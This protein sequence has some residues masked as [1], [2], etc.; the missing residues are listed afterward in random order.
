MLV[1]S[2]GYRLPAGAVNLSFCFSVSP[3]CTSRKAPGGA[4]RLP[5]EH[6]G[7]PVAP[8]C[9]AYVNA[10]EH[11][12]FLA[13][14]AISGKEMAVAQAFLGRR[15]LANF[16]EHCSGMFGTGGRTNTNPFLKKG[17]G[18]FASV[19]LLCVMP[20]IPAHPTLRRVEVLLRLVARM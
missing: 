13:L 15:T 7:N 18:M 10:S 6:L 17:F 1:C 9:C 20:P 3:G 19:R 14:F 12:N 11:L 4:C 2:F 8:F 5:G 16:G